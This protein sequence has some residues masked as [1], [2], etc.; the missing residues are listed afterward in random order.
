MLGDCLERMKEIPDGSVDMVLTD[1]P[2]NI[3][4]K[5]NFST[6]GRSGIDFGEWD[7]GFDLFSYI[8]EC[9]RILEKNGS[10]VVFNDWKN[11]GDIV[12]F[13]ESVGFIVKDMIRLEK[14]N[15]MP[16]NRDRRYVTDFECAIWFT[17]PK[18]KWVFNRQHPKYQRPKFIC[19]V[20]KGLHPTQKSL[21]LMKQIVLIHTNINQVVI[22]PFMGSGTTGVACV[23]LDREFIGIEM[24]KDYFKI[25]E[26]RIKEAQ[27]KRESQ[28]F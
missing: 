27:D 25:A 22:D 26:N 7:K 5:N 9:F 3:A 10:F 18:S 24:D 12:K 15:P 2:Y 11:L 28:L 19:S 16:R 21:S 4:R 20:D 14:S 23:N 13:S 17:M 1:P 8:S 6:M